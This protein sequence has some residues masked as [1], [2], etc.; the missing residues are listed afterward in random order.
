MVGGGEVIGGGGGGT[1]HGDGGLARV[2]LFAAEEHERLALLRREK[3]KGAQERDVFGRRTNRSAKQRI[4]IHVLRRRGELAAFENGVMK[5]PIGRFDLASPIGQ[6]AKALIHDDFDGQL[7]R[8]I[9]AAEGVGDAANAGIVGAQDGF[10]RGAMELPP[11]RKEF[12]ERFGND[13]AREGQFARGRG[14]MEAGLFW[15]EARGTLH[16]R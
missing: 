14:E 15:G 9:V 8:V 4:P 3:T 2:Q 10:D 1:V 12:L 16:R 7:C 13:G 6:C 11:L 5:E